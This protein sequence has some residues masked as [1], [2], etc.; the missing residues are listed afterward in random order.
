MGGGADPGPLAGVPLAVKDSSRISGR[1][2]ARGSMIYRDNIDEVTDPDIARLLEAGAILFARTTMPEFGWLY[3]THS[4]LWGV[5]HNPWR[6]GISPG[7][8]SGGSAAAL[9]AGATTIATG[10]DSTGSIRQ[11]ASQ[12]GIVGWQAPFDAFPCPEGAALPC[13]CITGP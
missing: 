11:P 7:G 4:R 12:C 2:S 13:T 9:A 3:T 1:R 8:S 6:H 10:G 5:T